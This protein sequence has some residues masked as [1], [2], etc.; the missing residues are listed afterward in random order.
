MTVAHLLRKNYSETLL[1]IKKTNHFIDQ[2]VINNIRNK[3]NKKFT[4][5][6]SRFLNSLYPLLDKENNFPDALK[7]PHFGESHCL[8]F[9]HQNISIA[10]QIKKI[11]PV[12]ITGAKAWHFSNKKNNQW[13][14]SLIQ[15]MKNH[16]YSDEFFISFGE[17]DCRKDEGILIHS[18]KTNKDIS[19]ICEK[20]I[21]G[22]L[23]YIESV[24]STQYSQKYYFGVPA[25]FRE[26]EYLDKLDIKR[27]EM[28]KIFNSILKKEVL[29]RGSFFLDVFAMTSSQNGENNN[30]HMCDQFHLAPQCISIL[31]KDHLHKP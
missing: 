18:I 15:Q 14:D 17:I 24:L 10:S 30:I 11:Q 3:N 9:A 16:N 29:L 1:G 27:I 6:Y 28:I 4:F 23:S 21:K 19:Q 2:G 8:S 25:P 12:L 13:K 31:L 26:K 5:H 22:Y 7:I 20:T